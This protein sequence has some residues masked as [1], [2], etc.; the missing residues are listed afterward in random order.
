M[1]IAMMA[2]IPWGWGAADGGTDGLLG[3]A[4]VTAAVALVLAWIGR[5]AETT[6]RIRDALLVVTIGGLG[7]R[8]GR[9]VTEAVII[10][11]PAAGWMGIGL[12]GALGVGR[13]IRRKKS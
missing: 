3:G 4:S 2:A 10:P 8:G 7:I 11:L 1:A 9:L 5:S 12:M 6:M 13:L